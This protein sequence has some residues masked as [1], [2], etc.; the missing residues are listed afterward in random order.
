MIFDGFVKS[1]PAAL[2]SSVLA[3]SA[4]K[5]IVLSTFYEIISF[6]RLNDFACPSGKRLM[7]PQ[8]SFLLRCLSQILSTPG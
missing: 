2:H 6:Q 3:C 1:P 4:I 5:A 8:A 7:P